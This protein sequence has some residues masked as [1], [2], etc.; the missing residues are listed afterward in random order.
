MS[1]ESPSK[2]FRGAHQSDADEGGYASAA[3]LLAGADAVLVC[4]GA[5]MS[6]GSL[7]PSG[8]PLPD[9]RKQQPLKPS[10]ARCPTTVSSN[11]LRK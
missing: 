4:A 11:L 9:Y 3:A 10:G 1:S 8:A 5:G 6:A 7:T 2:R